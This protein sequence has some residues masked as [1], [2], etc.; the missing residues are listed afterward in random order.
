MSPDSW[1]SIVVTVLVTSTK[2]S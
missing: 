1:F 2:F